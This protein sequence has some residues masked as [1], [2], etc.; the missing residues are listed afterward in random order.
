MELKRDQ[1]Y[2]GLPKQLKMMV[3]YL[4][5]GLHVRM[6]SY[7]LRAQGRLRRKILYSCPKAPEP[8]LLMASQ[9]QDY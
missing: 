6:Y 7:Y 2:G 8:K 1:F 4:K 9:A 5:V 3:A